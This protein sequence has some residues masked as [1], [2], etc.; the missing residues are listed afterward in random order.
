MKTNTKRLTARF[1]RSTRFT[2]TP[3]S[4]AA[5]RARNVKRLDQLKDLLLR[6]HLA[7]LP[8]ADGRSA[9]RHAANEAASLAWATPFPLLILP[10]LLEE[11]VEAT[12]RRMRQ[13]EDIRRR[14]AVLLAEAA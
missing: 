8:E 3:V 10:T 6:Q 12:A 14:S 5:D 7:T 2:V 1:A 13:Q 11:K 9:L 4:A